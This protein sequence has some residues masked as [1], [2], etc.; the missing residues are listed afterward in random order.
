MVQRFITVTKKQKTVNSILMNLHTVR[1]A[2][3]PV[4]IRPSLPTEAPEEHLTVGQL[5]AECRKFDEE[6]LR[7]EEEQQKR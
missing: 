2:S 1:S 5:L 3:V 6:K 7:K 4:R